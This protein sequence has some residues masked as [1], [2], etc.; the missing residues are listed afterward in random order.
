MIVTGV[1]VANVRAIEAAELSFK[2][3]F[4]LIVGVNGVGKSTVLDV[5]RTSMSHLLPLAGASRAKSFSFEV[6]DIRSDCPFLDV[7]VSASVGGEE[8]QH[9]SR[10]WRERIAADDTQNLDRLRREILESNRLR[11]RARTLLRELEES[12]KVEDTYVLSRQVAEF[13]R[14]ADTECGR[15]NCIYFAT[16]R[17][18]I[19]RAAPA[20]GK[21][22]GGVAAAYAAGLVA[23]PWQLRQFAQWMRAQ[24]VLADEQPAATQHINAL[25]TAAQRFLPSYSN[26][27]PDEEGS[28]LLIDR[29]GTA[30]EVGALSDGERGV[31]A[32]VLDLAGRLSQANPEMNDPLN[33][34]GAIVLID[35]ID[36]HLHPG[37]QRKIVRRLSEVFPQCQ[38]IATTHSPQVVGEVEHERIQIISDG[39]VITPTHSFGVDSSR[40]LEE[41]M[42]APPRAA[43]VQ[44]LL[45]DLSK[46]VSDKNLEAAKS[47]VVKLA[48]QL[49]END[50]EVIRARTLLEFLGGDE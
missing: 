48:E 32:M 27:R 2:P 46:Q 35:E 17:S 31:L 14:A 21:S 5:L 43:E 8:F 6:A 44:T 29:K 33:E 15:P 45:D 13:R 39:N 7:T 23:R 19:E 1:K 28:R 9:T 34:G 18:V 50:A 40:I 42:D 25:R 22:A 47:L 37:W 30:L 36:L 3:G 4:N 10:K 11:A 20:K 38:F 49:G 24:M 16:N 26:L 12:F 41:I